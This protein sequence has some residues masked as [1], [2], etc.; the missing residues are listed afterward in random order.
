VTRSSKT[1]ESHRIFPL[2]YKLRWLLV[3]PVILA[4]GVHAAVFAQ[5]SPVNSAVQRYVDQSIV[6]YSHGDLQHAIAELEAAHQ[7]A[8]G[9]PQINFMLGNALYRSGDVG[10][11]ADAYSKTLLVQPNHF[12]AHMSRGFAFFEA[13]KI[14][15]AVAEWAAAKKIDPREPFARA[16]LAVGLYASGRADDAKIQ[17]AGALVLNQKY[18]DLERLHVDIRW[19]PK[20]LSIVRQLLELLH[21]S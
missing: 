17:Y 11:A 19:K 21:A 13:G 12:E 8:P 20:A 18:G 4:L 15:Y 9:D 1:D 7:L 2:R 6:Y 10:G 3:S 5:D 14:G 16:A